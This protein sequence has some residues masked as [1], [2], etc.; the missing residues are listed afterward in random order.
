MGSAPGSA[1]RAA[2]IDDSFGWSSLIEGTLILRSA[3]PC[4]QRVRHVAWISPTSGCAAVDHRLRPNTSAGRFERPAGGPGN[5]NLGVDRKLELVATCAF[6]LEAIVVR[7][8]AALGY[9]AQV[10]SPGRILFVGDTTAICR[11]N[12]WLRTADRVLLRLAHFP[13][14]DF[15]Q[16]FD[17]TRAVPWHEWIPPDGEFPVSGR[18]TKS[19]LS[20]V[21]ACQRSVK[22]A[23]VESLRAGHGVE[24]LPE[25]G[26]R[27]KIEVAILKDE[28]S[29][30]LDTTG[31]SLHK[32]G[33]RQLSARAPLK[34]TL[35]AAMIQ[36]S[37][38]KAGR[39][40]IDPFCGS[41]TIPI[42]AALIGR[43]LAP[44]RA[45]Q[46]AAEDWPAIANIAWSRAREEAADL[47]LPDLP[48]R[49]LGT[50]IDAEVLSLAR[51]HAQRA[52]VAE[53]IHFQQRAFDQLFSKQGHGCVIANPPY[54][55]R[56]DDGTDPEALYRT[57]PAV[58]RRLPTWSHYILTPQANFETLIEK[59][60]DRRRKL[61]NGR[62]EC[63]FY[64]FH[65]PT[66]ADAAR[67]TAAAPGSNE[68]Q[69]KGATPEKGDSP[70]GL[71]ALGDVDSSP[72]RPAFGGVTAKMQEQAELFRS[73]LTKRARHLRRWPTKRGITCYRLYERDIP[74]IP[75]VVDR[76]E[77][78]LHVTEY[79][80]PHDRDLGQHAEWLELLLRTA[81][82][83]L[84][85]DRNHI[86]LKRRERQ[87]GAR[88]H[89]HLAQRQFEIPVQEDGLK[90][91]VNLSDYVD[92]GLFLDHRITRS[93]IREAA[94]GKSFLNL[95]GY[96]G[97]FTVYAAAGGAAHTTTVDWSRT[98]LEWAQRNMAANE[99]LGS[100]HQFL[101]LGAR[102][103]LDPS[104]QE[105]SAAGAPFDLAVVDPPTFSNSKRSNDDWEVQRDHGPLLAR[106]LPHMSPGGVIYFSTNFR[107]FHLDETSLVDCRVQEISR[108]TV[109]EDF[110]NRRVH[111]CWRITKSDGSSSAA[112]ASETSATTSPETE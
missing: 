33:Y 82:Q 22:K 91:I 63:T 45:R 68:P 31:P 25:S 92:T 47:A 8:L 41:G 111:R 15:D 3:V 69:Q 16:L 66:P 53:D 73:R 20:S 76:Y 40:L 84:E 18:S 27:Y 62:I 81:G 107:R 10:V 11:A 112:S 78:C 96:T 48:T 67:V 59:Q 94:A 64:Q 85:I 75:L 97:A 34:E 56:L 52:G 100:A 65:G 32:R 43:N 55:R 60:A 19:Q 28:V 95:F 104:E 5:L 74:E 4:G 54:G 9:D 2:S 35:A 17:T 71:E 23:I 51:H 108:Q 21:P 14:T 103:F 37:Y 83:V 109:P 1:G 58:L 99:L 102:E 110:R 7:E 79:E 13:A 12:L 44:G 106:L 46:F 101:R 89:E 72:A 50:D 105:L 36:L 29:L 70:E 57:M 49:I 30:S 77:D 24:S 42:E 39:P 6:G 90:F 87:R 88:Q 38:W 93:M 26:P 86:F 61:Y 80:R 98:Y